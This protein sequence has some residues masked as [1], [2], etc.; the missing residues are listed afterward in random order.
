MAAVSDDTVI[1]IHARR[2]FTGSE[3]YS[4]GEVVID[5]DR[6]VSVGALSDRSPDVEVGTLVPGFVDVHNHGGGGASFGDDPLVA[7][8]AHRRQG[9]TTM[10][11]SLVSQPIE[12]I[13][14]HLHTLAPLVADGT[15]GGIHLEGPWLAPDYRGAHPE[16]ALCDPTMSDIDRLLDAADGT[17]RMVTL[18]PE[19]RGG[20][21]AIDRLVSRGVVVALG[22]SGADYTT[23]AAAVGRGI[24]GATHLFNAM[25]SIHHRSPGPVLALLEDARVWL[26]MIVDGHHLD[27]ALAV[28]VATTYPDRLVLISD[29]MAAAN[30][31]DGHYTLGELAIDVH[32]GAARV[33][34]TDTLAGS[35][36]T[37]DL[38]I[39]NAVDAGVPWQQA[40][41][42]ATTL[43]ARFVGLDDVGALAVGS[44]ADAVVLSDDFTVERVL[45]RGE[46]LSASPT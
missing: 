18:A 4:P 1:V 5:G 25:P 41:R 34:G 31:G 6:I 13:E 7:V 36:L 32:H 22:H 43:P 46:W 12:V 11:A 28:W 2:L 20:F 45:H 29:A 16:A 15:L 14:Q 44:R 38:A 40:V 23:A 42:S 30:C 3:E 17:V 19:R 39:R 35:T 8:A 10:L 24:T 21:D 9:T 37:L 26:E 33:S 27:P